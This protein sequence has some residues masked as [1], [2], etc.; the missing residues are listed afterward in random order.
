M[1]EKRLLIL[2]AFFYLEEAREGREEKDI[3]GPKI[4]YAE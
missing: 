2:N 4:F 3:I 1:M